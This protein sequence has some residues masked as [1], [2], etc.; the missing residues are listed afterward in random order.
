MEYPKLQKNHYFSNRQNNSLDMKILT[1]KSDYYFMTPNTYSELAKKGASFKKQNESKPEK[2]DLKNKSATDVYSSTNEYWKERAIKNQKKME[3]IKKERYMKQGYV[4]GKPKI[5][6]R[7]KEIAK[8]LIEINKEI[9]KKENI[10][11]KKQMEKEKR[12]KEIKDELAHRNKLYH[13]TNNLRGRDVLFYEKMNMKTDANDKGKN[14]LNQTTKPGLYQREEKILMRRNNSNKNIK[15]VS[16]NLNNTM[17]KR[18]KSTKAVKKTKPKEEEPED[19]I[20]KV[21]RLLSNAYKE[22]GRMDNNF[23]YYVGTE[24]QNKTIPRIRNK[25]N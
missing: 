7:S 1:P 19:E 21:R 24:P 12:E 6:K 3:K 9:E 11:A 18:T 10:E 23:N 16:F 8:E 22:K 15:N 14:N 20:H 5:S 25:K 17:K 4:R 2:D 13:L